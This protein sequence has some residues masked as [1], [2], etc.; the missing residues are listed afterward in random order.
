MVLTGLFELIGVIVWLPG[1][2]GSWERFDAVILS[3]FRERREAISLQTTND[4][5]I[6][7]LRLRRRTVAMELVTSR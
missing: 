6:G 3:S 5:R 4:L 1:L 2:T 7:M